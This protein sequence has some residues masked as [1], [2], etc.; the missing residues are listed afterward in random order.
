MVS[1]SSHITFYFIDGRETKANLRAII[2][3]DTHF[4]EIKF[5]ENRIKAENAEENLC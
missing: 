5:L 3:R 4:I 2:E 1:Y